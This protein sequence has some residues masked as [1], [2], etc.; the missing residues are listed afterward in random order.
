LG[1]PR[2][3]LVGREDRITDHRIGKKWHNIEKIMDGDMDKIVG[4]FDK[5]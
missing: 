4:A 2:P 5:K 1:E 3:I